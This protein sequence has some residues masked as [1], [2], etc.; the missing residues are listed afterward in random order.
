MSA[1]LRRVRRRVSGAV[2]GAAGT[3]PAL[4]E[5]LHRVDGYPARPRS[6]PDVTRVVEAYA[7]RVGRFARQGEWWVPLGTADRLPTVVLIH[8]GFWRPGYDRHLQDGVAAV[9]AGAGHLVWNLDYRASDHPWPATLADLAAGYD[10]LLYGSYAPL[11]DRSRVAVVGHCAGGHLALWLAGR[12]RLPEG[13]SA[14][15]TP[16]P[17]SPRP[18]LAVSQAGVADLAGAVTAGLGDGAA[19]RLVGADP[20]QHPE[21]YAVADPMALLPTG[22]RT[23][24]IHGISDDTVPIGQSESYVAAARA[25]GDDSSSLVRFDGGHSEHLDP[26]SVAVTRLR[27]AL[28]A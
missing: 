22:I 26:D 28:S 27:E 15:L 19:R 14:V 21:R 2:A 20:A 10:H 11:V 6:V 3:V 16:A 24:L 23:V 13:T 8:G 25:V 12:H 1:L 5:L 17:G 7:P 18:A 9:L 4:G